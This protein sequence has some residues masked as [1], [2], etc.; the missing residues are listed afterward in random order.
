MTTK[1]I[2]AFVAG[3]Y[4]ADTH[5]QVRRNIEAARAVAE[6]LW[7]KGYAVICPHLNSAWMSGVTDEQDFLD[8]ALELL[9]RSDIVVAIGRPGKLSSGTKMEVE[10]AFNLV[11]PVFLEPIDI[12]PTANEMRRRLEAIK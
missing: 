11:I 5:A 10:E 3:P 6:E 2:V 12:I 8:G 1:K 4:R 9:R 7:A